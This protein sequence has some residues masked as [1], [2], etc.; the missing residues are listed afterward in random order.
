M[1]PLPIAA[2]LGKVPAAPA[3]I[4]Q[5]VPR[6]QR[7]PSWPQW[8]GTLGQVREA[9]EIAL[10][11]LSAASPDEPVKTQ[12]KLDVSDFTVKLD[13]LDELTSPAMERDRASITAFDIEV[14]SVYGI[15]GVAVRGSSTALGA[16]AINCRRRPNPIRRIVQA[17]TS[18]P[19]AAASLGDLWH[20]PGER[21][22]RR[23]CSNHF[24]HFGCG[25]YCGG[26]ER[27]TNLTHSRCCCGPSANRFSHQP[28]RL[29]VAHV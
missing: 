19:R 20:N 4:V 5:L 27:V 3:G 13:A 17:A 18:G 15:R 12:V 8:A 24:E 26:R 29:G 21:P 22:A 7:N 9:A 14:G 6:Y 25:D 23:V 28:D 10:T 1:V 16:L 2:H 11:T